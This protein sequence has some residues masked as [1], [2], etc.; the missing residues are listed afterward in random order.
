[1]NQMYLPDVGGGYWVIQLDGNE[2]Y[3]A[4]RPGSALVHVR[5]SLHVAVGEVDLNVKF[6][7]S[8]TQIVVSSGDPQSEDA[9]CACTAASAKQCWRPRA[10]QDSAIL[11]LGVRLLC[12]KNAADRGQYGD[13]W[14]LRFFGCRFHLP[15]RHGAMLRLHLLEYRGNKLRSKELQVKRK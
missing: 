5:R 8:T 13:C 6:V 2:V 1:M 14:S 3:T 4:V 10:D 9:D 11:R 7:F 15:L 12:E